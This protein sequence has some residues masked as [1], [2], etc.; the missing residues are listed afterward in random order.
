MFSIQFRI[1]EKKWTEIILIIFKNIYQI[2][3]NIINSVLLIFISPIHV[4]ITIPVMIL[5]KIKFIKLP[6]YA[7][8][9]LG[10][11]PDAFLKEGIL[12]ERPL[13]NAI[14]LIDKRITKK[15]IANISLLNYWKEYIYTV[16]S[17]FLI[18]IIYPVSQYKR[19]NYDVSNFNWSR[20]N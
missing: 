13:F 5:L 10:T 11:D 2:F 1:M 8:G 6:Y 14:W 18:Y 20:K 9:H 12:G 17:S 15:H 16:T 7:I 19:F 4:L 3:L